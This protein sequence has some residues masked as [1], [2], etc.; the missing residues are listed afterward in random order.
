MNLQSRELQ[1]SKEHLIKGVFFAKMTRYETWGVC[2]DA[3]TD[4]FFN[5]NFFIWTKSS[6]KRRISRENGKNLRFRRLNVPPRGVCYD[7]E[8][9]E[10][11]IS[12]K[13]SDKTEFYSF[14]REISRFRCLNIPPRGVCYDTE[15]GKILGIWTWKNFYLNKIVRFRG[16][17]FVFRV[18]T[19]LPVSKFKTLKTKK[20]SEKPK[21]FSELRDFFLK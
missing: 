4:V 9:G 10:F 17:F 14:S 18:L 20:I 1:V 8:N 11:L 5:G 12:L 6:E 15:N 16:V 21:I 3:K 13:S 7:T 2:Y 19:L